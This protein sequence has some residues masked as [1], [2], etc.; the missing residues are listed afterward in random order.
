MVHLVETPA[1]KYVAAVAD[2]V[3]EG[4]SRVLYAAQVRILGAPSHV[5]HALSEWT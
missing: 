5:T 3:G 4:F 1:G 2:S